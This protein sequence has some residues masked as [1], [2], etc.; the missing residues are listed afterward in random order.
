VVSVDGREADRFP[1]DHQQANLSPA[2]LLPSTLSRRYPIRPSTASAT[3][4]S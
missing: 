3:N 4:I 1:P 2:T